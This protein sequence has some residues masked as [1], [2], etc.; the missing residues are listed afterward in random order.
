MGGYNIYRSSSPAGPFA[1]VN[2][3]P[4]DRTAYF[5]DEGLPA[6][7]R[8]YYKVAAVD[9]SGNQG[10]ASGVAQATTSLPGAEGFPLD[11]D[12]ATP[13]SP[14]LAYLS[15][16][17][18][19]ELVTGAGEVYVVRHDGTE[20]LDGDD[21]AQTYGVFAGTGSRPVLGAPGGGR[22]R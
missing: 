1:K 4:T 16:D 14:C 9:S 2:D 11:L 19:A 20:L 10:T 22:S 3:L 7:T 8:F 13:C 5:R 6:M 15:G 21:N 17:T 18:K 12:A